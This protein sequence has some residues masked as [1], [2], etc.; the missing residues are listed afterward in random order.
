MKAPR[1]RPRFVPIVL[2]AAR[3]KVRRSLVGSVM[4]LA[5]ILP[6]HGQQLC[7]GRASGCATNVSMRVLSGCVLELAKQPLDASRRLAFAGRVDVNVTR[8]LTDDRRSSVTTSSP[9]GVGDSDGA[10]ELSRAGRASSS[11]AALAP[12]GQRDSLRVS[13]GTTSVPSWRPSRRLANRRSASNR[14]TTSTMPLSFGA[15]RASR[16]RVSDSH[17]GLAHVLE[18]QGAGLAVLEVADQFPENPRLVRVGD[19][20]KLLLHNGL[21]EHLS[22]RDVMQLDRLSLR[23]SILVG[24]C[25]ATAGIS[26]EM[27]M[28][29]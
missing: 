22:P 28:T 25:P 1:P 7:G 8:H 2:D 19:P 9:S 23:L 5:G 27:V 17:P 21:G 26:F 29:A 14:A 3:R 15:E 6:R 13:T 18:L 24:C 20:A 11:T 16:H 12:S 10:G 4:M